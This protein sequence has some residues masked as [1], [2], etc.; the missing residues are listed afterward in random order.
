MTSLSLSLVLA[1]G[2]LAPPPAWTDSAPTS[3]AERVALVEYEELLADY[4]AALV[5]YEERFF[6]PGVEHPAKSFMAR[7]DELGRSGDRRATLWCIDHL[8]QAGLRTS[9]RRERA[10]ELLSALFDGETPAELLPASLQLIEVHYRSLE[11]ELVREWCGELEGHADAEVRAG[12]LCALAAA[13]SEGGR[14]RRDAQVEEASALWMRALVDER[15]TAA[16]QRAAEALVEPIVKA[17]R[18]AQ[19][20][21]ERGRSEV[22]PTAEYTARMAELAELGAGPARLWLLV[23]SIAPAGDASAVQAAGRA[24]IDAHR[25]EGVIADLAAELPGLAA[26]VDV[27]S[28]AELAEHLLAGEESGSVRAAG[29]LAYAELLASHGDEAQAEQAIALLEERAEL[30]GSSSGRGAP[31]PEPSQRVFQ[32][33]H[34][35][36][37]REAPDFLTEDVDGTEFRLSDYRGKV[38]LLDFWG[39]W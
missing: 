28:A 15:G 34:L 33:R 32:W 21:F 29:L 20:D 3:G 13:V 25:G 6:V 9:E 14:T 1:A 23:N 18:R 39:F 2:A 37:G 30:L 38:V 4:E 31:E 24:L 8:R 36:V 16:S 22:E 5:E 35:Q 26:A 12:A 10:G 19:R 11:L 27:L 17:F 7:F